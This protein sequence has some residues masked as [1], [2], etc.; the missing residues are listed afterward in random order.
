MHQYFHILLRSDDEMMQAYSLDTKRCLLHRLNLDYP[1]TLNLSTDCF[2]HLFN[3][4]HLSIFGDHLEGRHMKEKCMICITTAII[5]HRM[6]SIETQIISVVTN[7]PS[8]VS[9]NNH[10]LIS[11]LL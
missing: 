5:I 1:R 6:T 11:A 10:I 8:R 3:E 2:H 7:E 4:P 9:S